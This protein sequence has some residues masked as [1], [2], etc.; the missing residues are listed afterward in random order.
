MA[1]WRNEQEA[2]E[3]MVQLR[4]TPPDFST[5]VMDDGY[6]LVEMNYGIYAVS[7]RP[8]SDKEIEE[9]KVSLGTALAVRG[10]GLAACEK[11]QVIAIN[12]MG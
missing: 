4:N 3:N 5:Y 8:L 7:S 2:R 6:G 10:F 12:D 1:D 11:G 9:G